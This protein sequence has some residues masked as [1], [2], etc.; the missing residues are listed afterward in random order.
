M[1]ELSAIASKVQAS[2]TM[3]VDSKFK[4]MKA[5]GI[6]VIGFGAGEPDFATPDNI[7]LA[8]IEAII[9]NQTKY[10]PASGMPALKQAV[11][12]RLLTDTGVAYQPSDIVISTG[13]K[14]IV[15]VALRTIINPGDE[16]ILPAP[17]WVSY[18]E[19]I[20]MVGG[21]P[22]IIHCR[23]SD[24][25]K[26][27]AEQLRAAC[28]PKTKALI[29]NNPSNPT[30]MMYGKAELEALERVCREEDLYVLSDEIYYK[31]LYD[32]RTFT[33]FAAL[34]ED[35]K[36]RT[37]VINGVSKS[38]AMTGWRIGYGA[39]AAPIAKLMGTYLSHSTSSPSTISQVASIEA[40]AGP[41]DTIETMRHAFE[42]R[43]NHLVERLNAIDGVSCIVPEG[44]FY[45]M[46][47]IER[48][49]GKTLFGQVIRDTDDFAALFLEK[50]L[51]AVVSCVG[52]DAPNF[53]RWS[54]AT[55]ME[56]ID[57]G[58]DRLER[59]LQEEAI[60]D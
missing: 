37:I 18:K 46:M 60:E 56:N 48:L 54:Y 45:V 11:C 10:T 50:G 52:F 42:Q 14:H 15:Y 30:G 36:A 9:T 26:M 19:L 38:Y 29:L 12:D 24:H 21:V 43:R 32:G 25:F 59:F 51:V 33:S 27:T 22:V 2:T 49:V 23:E 35:A 5:A 40:L 55:S 13:A 8:G 20:Q 1:K 58:V 41:Q 34:S 44:A 6:N 7:K 4:E 57:G 28:T 39:A 17:Y 31:L 53:V 3:A 47:N 16:V